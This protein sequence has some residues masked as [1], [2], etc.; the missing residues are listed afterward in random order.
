MKLT[1]VALYNEYLQAF[2]LPQFVP[3]VPENIGEGYRRNVLSDPDAAFRAHVQEKKAYLLGFFDDENGAFEILPDKV[4][5][6]DL[7]SFF[8]RGYL[9][10]HTRSDGDGIN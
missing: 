8:P 2:D 6:C 10:A 7:A 3:Q 9:A 1:I 5:L 4:L